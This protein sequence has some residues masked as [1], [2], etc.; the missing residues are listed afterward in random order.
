MIFKSI[1]GAGM[2]MIGTD[3]SGIAIA[4]RSYLDAIGQL[5]QENLPKLLKE[6]RNF[7]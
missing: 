6:L 7:P 1:Q 2:R 4:V 5:L 3:P